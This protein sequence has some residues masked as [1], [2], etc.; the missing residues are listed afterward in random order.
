MADISQLIE[1]AYRLSGKTFGEKPKDAR[2]DEHPFDRLNIHPEIAEAVKSRFDTG[3]YTDATT[4]ACICI[5]EAVR[6]Y[7]KIDNI[8]GVKL[9]RAALNGESPP[10][11]LNALSNKNEKS[12]QEGWCHIF[13]G[14]FQAIRNPRSHRKHPETMEECLDNLSI[15]SLLMRKLDNA[16]TPD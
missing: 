10:I 12:Q 8:E 13:A 5:E 6:D 2:E 3:H 11:R 9:M 14:I 1:L 4:N 15:L 16:Q 7:S